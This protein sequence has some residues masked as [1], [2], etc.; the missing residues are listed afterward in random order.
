MTNPIASDR[1]TAGSIHYRALI[2]NR[3]TYPRRLKKSYL[4]KRN[5]K[6]LFPLWKIG[7]ENTI[8]QRILP[9]QA[10]TTM[11]TQVEFLEDVLCARDQ[12]FGA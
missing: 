6:L 12:K 3:M 2:G 7:L 9:H 1:C 8:A 11:L 5:G 4:E 10:P